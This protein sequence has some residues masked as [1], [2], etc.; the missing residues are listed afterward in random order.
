[1][2]QITNRKYRTLSENLRLSTCWL[3]IL[4]V[5]VSV[6]KYRTLRKNLD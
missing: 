6:G 1:M 2:I 4:L 5:F 3:L